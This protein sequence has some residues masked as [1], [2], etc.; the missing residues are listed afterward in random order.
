MQERDK[1]LAE[2]KKAQA[3]LVR[4]ERELDDARREMDLTIEKRVTAS[5]SSVRDKAKLEAEEGLKLRVAE[6]EEQI[7]SM[8][9]QID[10]L[11]RKAEQGSQQLQGEVQELQLECRSFRGSVAR[12][13]PARSHRA[14]SE[15]RIR[16]RYP[17]ARDG[18][19]QSALRHHLGIPVMADRHSM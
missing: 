5:L 17:A 3:D 13:V 15:G 14:G 16:R 1:K 19:A 8:Q 12:Q 11:K 2:A 9:R 7:A 18:A 10:E 4:K 6:K